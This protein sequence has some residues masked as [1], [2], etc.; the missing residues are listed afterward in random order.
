MHE[1]RHGLLLT[2][3]GQANRDDVGRSLQ[4]ITLPLRVWSSMASL[5]KGHTPDLAAAHAQGDDEL[6]L[7]GPFAG[8][9]GRPGVAGSIQEKRCSHRIGTL[10]CGAYQPLSEPVL[11]NH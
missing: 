3:Q 6:S 11:D 8:G 10:A 4:A 2:R 1:C 5:A 9:E 7:A